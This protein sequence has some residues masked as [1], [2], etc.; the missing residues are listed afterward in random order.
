MSMR[1]GCARS[2]PSAP[3]PRTSVSPTRSLHQVRA[4][5]TVLFFSNPGCYACQEIIGTLQ[6][7]PGIDARIDSGSVAVVCVYIDEELD[8]WREYAPAYPARWL[9][10]YEG[11]G[12][13]RNTELYNVRAI[14][15]LYLLDADKRILLK[16]A[17]TER[18]V[19]YLQ[20]HQNQ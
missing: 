3:W 1:P 4:R 17:P 5:T 16:D 15:S 19:S 20:N 11:E 6:A 14:P 10:G 13:I 8:K 18:V 7:I 9:C 12:R 2:T